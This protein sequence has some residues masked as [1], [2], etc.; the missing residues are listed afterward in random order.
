LKDEKI[1]RYR[2]NPFVSLIKLKNGIKF[3]TIHQGDDLVNARTGEVSAVH[4]IVHKRKVDETEFVKLYAVDIGF[5]F[6]L[7]SGAIKCFMYLVSAL[8]FDRD[9]TGMVFLVYE[10]LA[11]F[12]LKMS[13]P[14]FVR[15]MKQLRDKEVAAAHVTPGWYFINPNIVFKGSRIQLVKEYEIMKDAET[16]QLNALQLGRLMAA[17]ARAPR[18]PDEENLPNFKDLDI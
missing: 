7:S 18:S 5:W 16:G 3:E 4:R 8:G 9:G 15:A 13:K 11:K 6:S 17:T 12:D 2:Y 14:T 10:E 1:K